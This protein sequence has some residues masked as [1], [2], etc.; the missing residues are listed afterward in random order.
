MSSDDLRKIHEKEF[1]M[2]QSVGLNELLRTLVDNDIKAEMIIN[3][4]VSIL[5]DKKNP[6]GTPF[7]TQEEFDKKI[8]AIQEE[9][10]RE[11]TKKKLVTPS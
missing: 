7:L 8:L 1:K 10:K 4:I 9:M 6:D 11:M 5:M 3:A 2:K